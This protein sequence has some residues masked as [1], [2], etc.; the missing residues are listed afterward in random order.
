[1]HIISSRIVWH[2]KKHLWKFVV[3]RVV[4]TYC[5]W[6]K[7]QKTPLHWSSLSIQMVQ[8]ECYLLSILY[9]SKQ[10]TTPVHNIQLIIYLLKTQWLDFLLD[11]LYPAKVISSISHCWI[12]PIKV[13]QLSFILLH[14]SVE[15]CHEIFW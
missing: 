9:P 7:D 11:L 13:Y 5:S 4:H 10:S 8:F 12:R 3:I 2:Y 6:H 14:C 15:L 1:M